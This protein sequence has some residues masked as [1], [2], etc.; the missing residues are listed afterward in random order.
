VLVVL[1]CVAA[2]SAAD[3]RKESTERELA[4]KILEATEV[5]GGLIVHV[6]CGDGRL[7]AALRANDSYLVHGLA[8]DAEDVRRARGHIQSL[9]VYGKVAVDRFDGE[10]LP[11]ADNLVSMV[12]ADDPGDVAMEEMMRVLAPGGVAYLKK[13]GT[14]KKTVKP[15]PEDI[16]DW[17]H[18]LHDAAGNAVA[19]D[20]QVGPP[21]H[22]RWIAEPL[23][24]RSHEFN[25]SINAL[26]SGGGRMFYILDEGMT[27]LTDLRF[28]ARWALYARDA[29]SGVLL[30]K[31]PVPNWGYR[32]WNTRG[33]WS[34]P[35]TLNRRVVTDGKRVFVTLG[36][37][38]P[39]TVLDAATGRTLRTIAGTDGTDEIV[40]CN[41]VLLLCVREQLSVASPPTDKQKKQQ[42]RRNPHEWN[43]APPGTA[44][45]V[46]VDAASGGELWRL[47]S[48]PL[49]VLTLAA[50]GDR[51]CFHGAD[52]I[53][54]LDL[55]T[56][57]RQ[58]TS[59][60]APMKG[61]R[62]SGGTL[63]MHGG[64]VLFT[65]AKGLTAFSDTDGDVLWTSPRVSG[66]GISHPPDL[67]VAD[68]LVWGGDEPKMHS[69]TR[70]AVKREG[71]DLTTGEVKRT[72]EVPQLFSPLHHVRC[73]RSKATDRYLLLPKRGIEYLDLKGDDHMRHDWLR[74]MCHYG[75]MPCNGLL[76]VPPS[77]CFCYPGV[78]MT[79]FLA[80]AAE[81][82][83][84]P[85]ASGE[86]DPAARLERGPAYSQPVFFPGSPPRLPAS[87]N[88]PT[89]R[90]DPLRSG[91]TKTAVPTSLKP[92][93]EKA[94]GG[95]ITAPVVADGG[96]YVAKVDAHQVCR[97]APDIGALAWTFTAGGRVDSPP[98][99]HE[100][101][102]L[103]GCRDGWVY[104]LRAADGELVWRFRAAPSDRRIVAFDQVESPW[105]VPGS[106][107]L[108]D[109]VAYV[110]A[111]RSSFLDGGVYLYG[112]RPQTG[113]VLYRTCV[114]GPWPDVQKDV[115]R[116]FDMDGTKSDVL[117][118]D[119]VH[120]FLYQMAFDKK[121][122]DVTPPRASTL[123]DR[124]MGRHLIATAGFLDDTWFDRNF[125]A[126]WGRWPGFYFTNSGPKAGQI[127]VFDESTTYGLHVFTKRLR[128][129][130]VFTPGGDGYELFADDN[131]NEPVL[132]KN[133]IDREKGPGFSRAADPKWSQ[134]IPL[135]VQAMVLAG[136]RLFMAGTPDV[137][138]DDEPYAAF[139]GRRGAQLWVVS[140][141][142]GQ[143]LAEYPLGSL[144]AFDGL[145]AA[146]ERLYLATAD[147]KVQC[148][149]GR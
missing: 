79:G 24:S 124:K 120:L 42:R 71:R 101:L 21:K 64:V 82:G 67:F 75:V 25:P 86:S 109:G 88:W 111:G 116:P 117:V 77:H 41:G 92:A 104:C 53:T 135:R 22:V 66:P 85:A 48:R 55:K 32:E 144:P 114:E 90:H 17:T 78:N 118:T 73:Y 35:L 119:G 72:I 138:P 133:S 148:F 106:V 15:R 40:L 70:T 142:D 7:T 8:K 30:W 76:Y 45:I 93:W 63:V 9:G 98:T 130:P 108:L 102:V 74:A 16:D 61:S 121:L 125:W 51:V 50:L 91:H 80:L 99:V 97:L 31:Q 29:F 134:Q 36:Y 65:S 52:G 44:A 19:A 1:V 96:L 60:T 59:G 4:R 131:D 84:R 33:M 94:L 14:W 69:R 81:R 132:A 6:S 95:K 37:K 12:V 146:G 26:V 2:V 10:L 20:L 113:E 103:F 136:D 43:I 38:A 127:V 23:W 83:P 5:K 89:Y 112:L 110:A 27:G 123:G 62:H 115:G 13:N 3:V 122:N 126:Y 141:A 105:P 47:D 68:G 147:G 140:A 28:P 34:A 129:S 87:E 107:L 39:A 49:T 56:G 58:W 18:Y 137:V 54:C 139:E 46:A 100:G 149:A 57:M 11:Y 128:L 143:K 145:I